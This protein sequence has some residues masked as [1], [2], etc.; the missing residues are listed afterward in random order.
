MPGTSAC[1]EEVSFRLGINRKVSLSASRF[2]DPSTCEHAPVPADRPTEL[3]LDRRL[4]EVRSE[5]S[6]R[7]W[8]QRKSFRLLTT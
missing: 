2:L 4:R 7:G 1:V 8:P 3:A 6:F 5:A